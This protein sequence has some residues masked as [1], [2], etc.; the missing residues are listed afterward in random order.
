[1]LEPGSGDA[2]ELKRTLYWP[3]ETIPRLGGLRNG[4]EIESSPN[5]RMNSM[6]VESR[7]CDRDK[8]RCKECK[9]GLSR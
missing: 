3:R 5:L 6:S 7:S 9:H 1:M 8:K 4:R 2:V